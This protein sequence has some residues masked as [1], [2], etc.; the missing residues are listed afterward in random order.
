MGTDLNGAS[1]KFRWTNSPRGEHAET[2]PMSI[3]IAWDDAALGPYTPAQVVQLVECGCLSMDDHAARDGDTD[4]M[5][6]ASLLTV[7]AASHRVAGGP[8]APPA[9]RP[10]LLATLLAL[11]LLTV[12][13]APMIRRMGGAGGRQVP[14]A[15]VLKP[16]FR[17]TLPDV[18]D[19]PDT[20]PVDV[21]PAE[22]HGGRLS[23]TISLA[24][25]NASA[26]ASRTLIV[27]AYPLKD[28]EP[29]LAQKK[30]A[31][32]VELDRLGPLLESAEAERKMRVAAEQSASQALLDTSPASDLYSAVRFA[33][34]QAAGAVKAA[35][36]NIR[37]YTAQRHEVTD[38]KYYLYDLPVAVATA[39]TNT[40]GEFTLEL[41]SGG[42]FAVVA[43]DLPE[44]ATGGHARY[45]MVKVFYTD[46]SEKT[47]LLSD[48]N[49][50]SVAS[51]ESLI[52]TED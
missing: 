31:A 25:A 1:G 3:Y 20:G 8:P 24:A 6:L 42:P 2:A 51:A 44:T 9:R 43:A 27:R 13:L 50:T 11:T 14:P 49:A 34:Q 7:L 29:Y 23:G 22:E 19:V 52:Q 37:Y 40:Q 46:T 26:V 45:W 17:V 30:A 35:E 21:L 12:L 39:E 28:L 15:Q 5:P 18:I 10:W 48:R 33:H 32:Q 47:L 36:E 16:L 4:W 41:P 38:G